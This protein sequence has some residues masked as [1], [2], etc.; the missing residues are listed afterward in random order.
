MKSPPLS[1]TLIR[2]GLS[3]FE[4]T[5]GTTLC[6]P[7]DSAIGTLGS[8]NGTLPSRPSESS[9]GM[10]RDEFAGFRASGFQRPRLSIAD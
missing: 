2:D 1:V 9:G 3:V 8:D 5:R 4:D 10:L 6:S 7:I